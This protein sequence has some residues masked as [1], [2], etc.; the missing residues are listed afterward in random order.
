MGETQRGNETG[1][2]LNPTSAYEEGATEIYKRA[3]FPGL[4]VFLGMG[5]I[6]FVA[7]PD[8]HLAP[9][10]VTALASVSLAAGAATYVFEREHSLRRSNAKAAAA[11]RQADMVFGFMRPLV[12]TYAGQSQHMDSAVISKFMDDVVV[13]FLKHLQTMSSEEASEDSSEPT[14]T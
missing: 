4:L 13:G 6:G 7:V 8:V 1:G 3:G 14:Q 12:E 10:L 5:A 9:I 11:E 2:M